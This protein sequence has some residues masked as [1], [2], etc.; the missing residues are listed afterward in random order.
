MREFLNRHV[1]GEQRDAYVAAWGK[2]SG[3]WDTTHREILLEVGMK[4]GKNFWSEGDLSFAT[5]FISCLRSP[6][7]YFTKITKVP[8]AYTL[9]KTF[10]FVNVST[11]DED[12]A[13]HAFFDSVKKVL[14]LTK[15]PKSGDNWFER[16]AGLDLREE[17]GDFKKSEV[18][19]P[20]AGEGEG[21]IRLLS[22]NST[23]SAPEGI[24][25]LRFYADELSRADTKPKYLNAKG[26]YELGLKNTA[27]AFPNRVGKVIGW[28]YPNDTDYDLT[29][30]RYEIANTLDFIYA[31]RLAT[32]QFNPAR[33]KDMF[34]DE[35]KADPTTA[36]RIYECVKPISRDNFYQPYVEKLKE[37][38]TPV[39]A[40]KV[41]YKIIT[42]TS[43]VK[44]K[45][46]KF[47]TV[48]ILS[49]QGDN[50]ERCFTHDPSKTKDRYV[51][52]GGYNETIDPLKIDYFVGDNP[53]VIL[54]NKKPVEDVVIIIE[55]KDGCP[56]DYLQIGKIWTM[57]IKAFPNTRSI[58]SDHFQNE[59]LRQEIIAQG[60]NSETYSFSQPLQLKI[61]TML[62]ANIWNNNYWVCE[63]AT[64]THKIKVNST[65]MK[66]SDLWIY[67]GERLIKDG[68]KI[69]HPV[70]GSKD[71]QDGSAILNYDLMNLEAEGTMSAVSNLELLTEEKLRQLAE[72]FMDKEAELEAANTPK[73]LVMQRISESLGLKISEVE[74]LAKFVKENYKY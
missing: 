67:E 3:T 59:K 58:N 39:V 12:Q 53:E 54:T 30:E 48:E 4:G 23:K 20:V 60:I 64:E 31:R 24:H 32:W 9:E 66:S 71:S 38:I 28:S 35:Y 68:N 14:K 25:M 65:L 45:T 74:K 47:T 1:E 22:F 41:D 7:E 46:Y 21:G 27:A 49:I 15:D 36:R 2:D 17:H 57:L 62:R 8:I 50:K 11:V 52:K 44:G 43:E 19:F 51:I 29:H 37:A 42:T 6:H 18:I 73:E 13:R 61:Y 16:Y 70:H 33:T 56:I 72:R 55:P 26:L 10:D 69:D 5:Y 40:N 63:D 34:D